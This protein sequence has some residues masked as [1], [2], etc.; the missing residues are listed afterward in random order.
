MSHSFRR[1]A[2]SLAFAVTGIAAAACSVAPGTEGNSVGKT[3]PDAP[4]SV[5]TI[6]AQRLDGLPAGEKLLI[7]LSQPDVAYDF[8]YSKAPLDFSRV[9]LQF[10]GGLDVAMNEWLA[11]TADDGVDSAAQHPGHLILRPNASRVPEGVKAKL[12]RADLP[13]TCVAPCCQ[14]FCVNVCSSEQGPC[15]LTCITNCN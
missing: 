8:D 2:C 15:T 10:A 11:Q 7:D 13:P 6:N 3:T 9:E 1:L 4:P 5:E 14:T 12:V